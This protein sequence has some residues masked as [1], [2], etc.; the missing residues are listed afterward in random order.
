MWLDQTWTSLTPLRL[1]TRKGPGCI[2]TI[3]IHDE[4]ASRPYFLP[5]S[6]FPGSDSSYLPSHLVVPCVSSQAL[7]LQ[8]LL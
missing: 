7:Q 1:P 4:G 5:S 8:V 3:W 6:S 2:M